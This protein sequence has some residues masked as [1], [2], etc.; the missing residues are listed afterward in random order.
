MSPASGA[1]SGWRSRGGTAS[2]TKRRGSHYAISSDSEEEEEDDSEDKSKGDSEDESEEEFAG[3]GSLL[4][5]GG[6][7]G[8]RGS[9]TSSLDS[10]RTAEG[11]PMRTAVGGSSPGAS[12]ASPD[13]LAEGIRARYARLVQAQEEAIQRARREIARLRE[14]EDKALARI[15]SDKEATSVKARSPLGR[16]SSSVPSPL[17][18]PST[19][20]S[21][22]RRPQRVVD[23]EDDGSSSDKEWMP[24]G[25]DDDGLNSFKDLNL[26]GPGG[27]A[28]TPAAGRSV[29]RRRA[30][31]ARTPVVDAST[32]ES[33][34]SES[35]GDDA[36]WSSPKA[37]P[38]AGVV[39]GGGRFGTNSTPARAPKGVMESPSPPPAR[40]TPAAGAPTGSLSR[41]KSA[42]PHVLA[43][44][45]R[46]K[47]ARCRELF[48]HYNAAVFGGSLPRDLDISWSNRLNTT[49]GLSHFR[50]QGD[51][52]SARVEL[53]SKVVDSDGRLRKTL[54]HELCHVAAWL[55]DRV[56]KPPHGPVFKKWADLAERVTGVEVQTCHTYEIAFK[57]RYKCGNA[58]CGK[59]YGR[60]SRSIDP[61]TQACGVC[62]GR[63]SLLGSF[64]ADGTPAKVQ[65]PNAFSLFVRDNMA[66]ARA[67]LPRGATHAQV[68][69]RL[70]EMWKR[71]KA[72]KS[73][74][75]FTPRTPEPPPRTPI[76]LLL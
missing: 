41:R 63:L 49:A 50:R 29:P 54:L 60:H 11:E 10:Y 62:G 5:R 20:Q 28:T 71:E 56:A 33:D 16:T 55:V 17:G 39:G 65:P 15:A 57:F 59:E 3:V 24:S 27:V 30:A 36:P 40:R 7:L 37:R 1:G 44:F 35:D 76:D 31:V 13:R 53:S 45:Q 46:T 23:S 47:D 25:S 22:R 26:A 21:V 48:L 66:S 2:V 75:Q 4:K 14:E 69:A 19:P 73:Q 34:G 70:S 18:S 32:S 61:K 67:G 64:K 72:A 9:G 12:S 52:H 74:P 6:S 51:V 8:R 38:K 42:A 58:W 43:G 68:M